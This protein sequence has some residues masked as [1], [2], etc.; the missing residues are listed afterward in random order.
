MFPGFGE[1]FRVPWS[2]LNLAAIERSLRR[3]QRDF[4]AINKRLKVQRDPMSDEIVER[5]MAGYAMVDDV[6]A[7]RVDLF[8]YGHSAVWLELNKLVLCGGG[9]PLPRRYQKHITAAQTPVYRGEGTPSCCAATRSTS[10]RPRPGS[11]VAR[12]PGSAAS[13]TGTRA[14]ARSHPGSAPLAPMSACSASRSSTSRATTA[15]VR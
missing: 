3:V 1:D 2:R 11:T 5:I 7:K 12:S 15:P 4:A 14:T 6:L 10:G 13:S 8:A 9:P